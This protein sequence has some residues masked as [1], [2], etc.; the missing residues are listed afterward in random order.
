MFC[1]DYLIIRSC[2]SY[3]LWSIDAEGEAEEL[4]VEVQVEVELEGEA[5]GDGDGVVEV[6]GEAEV[7]ERYS[8]TEVK[9]KQG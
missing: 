4:E 6:K 7:Y 2:S 9:D 8:D 3:S 5:E 1:F